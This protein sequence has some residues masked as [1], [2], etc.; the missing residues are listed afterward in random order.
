MAA[1]APDDPF[2]ASAKFDNFFRTWPM[3]TKFCTSETARKLNKHL[4]SHLKLTQYSSYADFSSFLY[5]SS[6]VRFK[7]FQCPVALKFSEWYVKKIRAHSWQCR[8]N[9]PQWSESEQCLTNF[10]AAPAA[11]RWSEQT[12]IYT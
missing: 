3:L 8:P 11:R 7:F 1:L 9:L 4:L 6:L 5:R 12:F 10:C 2:G